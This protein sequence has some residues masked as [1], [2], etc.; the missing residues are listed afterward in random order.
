MQFVGGDTAEGTLPL[1]RAFRRANKGALLAY[2]VEVDPSS[3][4]SPTGNE[5]VSKDNLHHKQLIKEIIHSIDVAADFEDSLTD[6]G[7]RT[8]VAVK[9]VSP[10]ALAILSH[11]LGLDRLL[12]C[13]ML[14]LSLIYP[15]TLF[16][17][18]FSNLTKFHSQDVH[19]LLTW[20]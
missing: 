10:G 15:S 5:I 8:W 13:P 9:L 14:G 19:D 6:G 18:A 17:L 2:S 16:S 12:F 4:A 1:L 11:L 7:R 20:M 3:A